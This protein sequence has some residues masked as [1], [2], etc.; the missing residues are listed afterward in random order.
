MK[1]SDTEIQKQ[2]IKKIMPQ[3]V[4]GFHDQFVKRF[5][6]DGQPKVLDKRRLLFLKDFQGYI[7]PVYFRLSYFFSSHFKYSFLA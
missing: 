3:P 1:A 5:I 6:K 7:K 2:S 4:H